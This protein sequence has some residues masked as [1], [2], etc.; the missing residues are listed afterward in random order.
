MENLFKDIKIFQPSEE[1]R[2]FEDADSMEAPS[3]MENLQYTTEEEA[4][5]YDE[6]FPISDEPELIT[7][8]PSASF[9]PQDLIIPSL[10]DENTES[11]HLTSTV[12]DVCLELNLTTHSVIKCERCEQAFCFHF[13]SNIDARYC[14]NCMSDMSMTK[15]VIT[16]EYVHRDSERG[17]TSIYRRRAREVK[18]SGLDW[19]FAQRKISELSDTELDLTIEYHRNILSLMITEQ[20]ARRN[21]KMHRYAGIKVSIP[22]PSTTTVS[23]TTTTTTKKTRTV[24]K[25]KQQEQ[26]AAMLKSML[27][28]G[29]TPDQILAKLRG[30]K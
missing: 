9:I 13:A 6:E 2:L 17:I 4:S 7:E 20:E 27:A 16:K 5:I 22:T 10:A 3:G 21:A 29:T 11:P 1:D 25:T 8:I 26:L 12:C 28:G 14:V 24:S 23:D 15:Q 18:I 30:G 19:L